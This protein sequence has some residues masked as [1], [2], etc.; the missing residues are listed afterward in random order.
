MQ[1]NGALKIVIDARELRTSTGRY[2]ER[3]LHY[4]QQIDQEHEYTVLLTPKDIDGWQPTNPHFTKLACPYKEFTFAEQLGLLR[5]INSLEADLVHFA[6]TQQPVLYRGRVVTTIHDLTTARFRNP[7]KN[8][9]VFTIKQQVY[10]WVIR[11]VAKKS[12]RVLTAS[13]FVK[14]DVVAYTRI[15][16]GKVMV[17]YEA[18]DK[19]TVAPE[20]VSGLE[21]ASF[22]LYVGR[23]QPHKNLERLVQAFAVAQESH[24]DLRLVLAGKTDDNYKRLEAWVEKQGIQNVVF[25]GFVTEGQLRWLY[26]HARAYVF[27]SLS[28]GFGLPGLEAMQYG[29]PVVSSNA[30]CLPEIYK[31]AALYFDPKDINDMA[32]KISAVLD[33]PDLARQLAKEGQELV[34]TY[35]W[36][37]TAEQTLAVYNEVLGR[38]TRT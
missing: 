13:A 33:N 38:P 4:L 15:N 18:A 12:V 9:L 10:K 14:D 24:Q 34:K 28:E 22:L 16:P 17:T 3:L 29:L 5:Q 2:V 37:R 26:E 21:Q 8:W 6:M 20:S 30:T 32:D 31:S 35:S 7:T 27:P 1:E 36:H 11:R 23:P 25:T 19:I